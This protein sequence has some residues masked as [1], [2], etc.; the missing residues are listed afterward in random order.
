MDYDFKH[1][2]VPQGQD[3]IVEEIVDIF[4]N[5]E[6]NLVRVLIKGNK[7]IQ[8][9][10][11]AENDNF[12][13][14]LNDCEIAYDIVKDQLDKN[15]NLYDNYSLEISSPGIERP[16]TRKKDFNIWS[17]NYVKVKLF[18]HDN[19]PRRFEAKLMGLS[20]EGINIFIEDDSQEISG[21]YDLQPLDVKEIILSWVS[22]KPP[23]PNVI[24]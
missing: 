13:M 11:L 22:D 9:Q 4:S 1:L 3:N 8:I 21:E 24:G 23:I 15:P 17:N 20:E 16:L 14:S 19:L 2:L 12:N 6:Y 7:K 5:S 10:I 18:R